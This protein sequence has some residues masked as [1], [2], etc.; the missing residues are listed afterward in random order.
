MGFSA[1][2]HKSGVG[3]EVFETIQCSEPWGRLYIMGNGDVYIY[4]SPV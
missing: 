2:C 3:K 1:D 4:C